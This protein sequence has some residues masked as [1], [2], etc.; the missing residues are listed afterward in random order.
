MFISFA[1]SVRLLSCKMLRTTERF[2]WN[3]KFNFV[4][5][6]RIWLK[7]DNSNGR[8]TW[9]PAHIF[10]VRKWMVRMPW[11]PWLPRESPEHR[12]T[13]W[14]ESSV[15]TSSLRQ[16][17]AHRKALDPK[18]FWRNWRRSH[19]QRYGERVRIV[20]LCVHFLTYTAFSTPFFVY[21]LTYLFTFPVFP[22]CLFFHTLAFFFRVSLVFLYMRFSHDAHRI[23]AYRAGLVCPLNWYDWNLE[24]TLCQRGLP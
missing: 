15:F 20:M 1:I 9:I 23:N 18:Q 11:L 8:I 3:F 2:L 10:Y 17:C 7:S 21:L 22:F 6:F 24:W 13:T 5:V 19:R 12:L 14:R 4:T 16:T